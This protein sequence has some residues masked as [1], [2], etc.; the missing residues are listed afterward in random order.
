MILTGGYQ[1]TSIEWEGPQSVAVTFRAED[2]SLVGRH[3][4]LYGNRRLLAETESPDQRVLRAVLPATARATPLL[5]LSVDEAERLADHGDVFP[6]EA[7]NRYRV[8]W[9]VDELPA[10]LARFDVC[11][12]NPDESAALVQLVGSV[13]RVSGKTNYSSDLPTLESGLSLI[14][15]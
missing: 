12:S 8:A 1:I 15:I 13:P 9:S 2:P 4:Q 11:L 3:W 14:H 6:Q 7:W 10:E 5:L